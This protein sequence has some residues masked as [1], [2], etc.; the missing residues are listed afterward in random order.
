MNIVTK[1]QT[2]QA[3]H[4]F[5]MPDL[6]TLETY[7]VSSINKMT[8]TVIAQPLQHLAVLRPVNAAAHFKS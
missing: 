7:K 1:V 2:L 3:T 6:G 5:G 4:N 8:L